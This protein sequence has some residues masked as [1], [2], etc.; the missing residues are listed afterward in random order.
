MFGKFTN[1]VKK[2]FSLMS[3]NET[4][5]D[6]IPEKNNETKIR[7]LFDLRRSGHS[8]LDDETW[9]DLDLFSLLKSMDRCYTGIGRQYLYR[10]LRDQSG[11]CNIFDERY[12]SISLIG[13]NKEAIV[14]AWFSPLKKISTSGST[15]LLYGDSPSKPTRLLFSFAWFLASV[16]TVVSSTILGGWFYF[17]AALCIVINVLYSFYFEN[18]DSVNQFDLECISGIRQCA[19]RIRTSSFS[20]EIPSKPNNFRLRLSLSIM[21]F[22]QNSSNLV[23]NNAAYIVNAFTAYDNLVSSICLPVIH[24]NLSSIRGDYEL[25]GSLDSAI[26]IR[27]YLKIKQHVK[28]TF[29]DKKCMTLVAVYHPSISDCV[30]NDVSTKGGSLLITGS[31]MSGKTSFIRSVGINVVVANAIGVCFAEQAEIPKSVVISSI[32]ISDSIA[33]GKSYFYAELERIKCM[34]DSVASSH[35]L[36]I[37]IIDEIFK[38]TN[39]SERIASAAAVLNYLSKRSL[40]LVTSHD[41][42][43]YDFTSKGYQAYYFSETDDLSAPFDYKLRPGKSAKRNAIRLM[44]DIGIPD[45]IVLEANELAAKSGGTLIE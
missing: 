20:G 22:S 33:Q 28:A 30:P 37:C 26:T 31:N 43:L 9:D 32:N 21:Q 1:K 36:N 16:V 3:T 39:T 12:N 35:C 34:I 2:F 41:A 18:K 6:Y 44:A 5:G 45:E 23:I 27:A 19:N 24:R 40:V 29:T 17:I 13:Q 8:A 42:E 14:S 25:I 10:I 4:W 7:T 15:K 11:S 38:G